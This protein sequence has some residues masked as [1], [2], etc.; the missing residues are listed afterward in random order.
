VQDKI[1]DGS[2]TV[3]CTYRA[4]TPAGHPLQLAAKVMAAVKVAM[5]P[6]LSVC[7]RG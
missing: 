7:W 2:V 4:M 5:P 6:V 3:F 1:N